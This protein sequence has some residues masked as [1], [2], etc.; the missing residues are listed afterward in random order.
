M[1]KEQEFKFEIIKHIGDLTEPNGKG[2]RTEFN[3]VS[4]NGNDAKY[5]IRSWNET[6]DKMG[7][8][9]A[10]TADECITLK[11]LLMQEFE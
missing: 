3:L 5:D 2:W 7:K 6:H 9:V 8:G 1:K 10:L 4:F 11:E